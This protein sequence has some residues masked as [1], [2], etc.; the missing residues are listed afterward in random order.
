MCYSSTFSCS[1]CYSI[2]DSCTGDRVGQRVCVYEWT[3]IYISSIAI[4]NI[5]CMY[6]VILFGKVC[7]VRIKF[8]LII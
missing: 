7:M 5:Y 1:V 3:I 8:V 2:R 4:A 6:I